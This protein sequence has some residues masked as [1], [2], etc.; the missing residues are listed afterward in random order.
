MGSLTPTF[1]Q[2]FH[3]RYKVSHLWPPR[4]R[5][6]KSG[7]SQNYYTGQISHMKY[8]PKHM[9]REVQSF[10]IHTGKLGAAWVLLSTLQY[11]PLWCGR[12]NVCVIV[13][14]FIHQ[15]VELE[16]MNYILILFPRNEPYTGS[17]QS[18]TDAKQGS[19]SLIKREKK[20]VFFVS[21]NKDII[22]F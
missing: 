8:L 10:I 16:T 17:W 1:I 6:P 15:F 9:S 21:L 13:S 7:L 20:K 14:S 2:M 18:W 22:H 4:A 11:W 5:T 12:N 19:G 3:F